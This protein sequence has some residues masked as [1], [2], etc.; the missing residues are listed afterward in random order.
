M[1]NDNNT[2]SRVHEY[3]EYDDEIN[4]LHQT[5]DGMDPGGE[6]LEGVYSWAPERR[7][8]KSSAT[9]PPLS[10]R[11]EYTTKLFSSPPNTLPK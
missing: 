8:N 3:R 10:Y 9:H 11:G 2:T 5:P 1:E 7:D 6:I 4:G